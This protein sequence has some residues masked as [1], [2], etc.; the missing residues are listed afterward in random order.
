MNIALISIGF[1]ILII[2][3]CVGFYFL[4]ALNEAKWWVK[5]LNLEDEDE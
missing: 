3:L 1:G 5:R 4:G 2:L